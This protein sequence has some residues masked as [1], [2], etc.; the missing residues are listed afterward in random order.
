[1]AE[2]FGKSLK[3]GVALDSKMRITLEVNRKELNESP[4]RN[5]H[6]LVYRIRQRRGLYVCNRPIYKLKSFIPLDKLS[7]K[8]LCLNPN[9]KA[10]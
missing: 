1:M 9:P 6:V 3:Q 8:D 5:N 2:L 7:I 10:S 4:D